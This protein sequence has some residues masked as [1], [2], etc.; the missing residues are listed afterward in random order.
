MEVV[1]KFIPGLSPFKEATRPDTNVPRQS[2]WRFHVLTEGLVC[3]R[4]LE[5]T[6]A[7]DEK[8]NAAQ[9]EEHL[10]EGLRGG[11]SMD[12]QVGCDPECNTFEG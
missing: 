5:A 12:C 6:S 11:L 2:S 7:L 1:H 4:L 8:G 10:W 3:L 9:M